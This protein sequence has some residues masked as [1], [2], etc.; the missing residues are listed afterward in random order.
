MCWVPRCRQREVEVIFYGKAV[1]FKHWNEHANGSIDLK[2]LLKIKEDDNNGKVRR[3][4][5]RND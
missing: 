2:A 4:Q 5:S 1:C 3:V